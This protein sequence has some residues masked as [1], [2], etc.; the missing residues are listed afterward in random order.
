[1]SAPPVSG[2]Q[3]SSAPSPSPSSSSSSRPR[4]AKALSKLNFKSTSTLDD[5]DSIYE[6]V[7][8]YS[9]QVSKI[10]QQ[11]MSS[12]D[13]TDQMLQ[14]DYHAQ[15]TLVNDAN[16]N[17]LDH[18]R[19]YRNSYEL[20]EETELEEFIRDDHE[21]A[22]LS[23]D[24]QQDGKL[25]RHDSGEVKKKKRKNSW[26]YRCCYVINLR[27][28]MFIYIFL[29]VAFFL[30]F[31]GSNISFL[32]KSKES[33]IPIFSSMVFA[34]EDA[35]RI[36]RIYTELEIAVIAITLV[37][38]AF[39]VIGVWKSSVRFFYPFTVWAVFHVVWNLSTSA[40]L[41][42]IFG[43]IYTLAFSPIFTILW[44]IASLIQIYCAF[45][46]FQYYRILRVSE[47]ILQQNAERLN[48]YSIQRDDMFPLEKT[49]EGGK[50][51]EQFKLE[52]VVVDGE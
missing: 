8:E 1:M 29:N 42:L 16:D 3:T 37:M 7:K 20:T 35:F 34:F 10:C 27:M 40:S 38:N 13:S 11:N 47:K 32:L 21:V 19:K 48:K 24:N 49:E 5:D 43:D 12:K 50:V 28:G 30:G 45:C 18:E 52:K 39:G 25:G 22:G 26:K 17:D 46:V 14:N 6:F 4:L 31:L 41:L 15:N 36:M 2:G 44:F 23:Y 51:S 9:P 33:F